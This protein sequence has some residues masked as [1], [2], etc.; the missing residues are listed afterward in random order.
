MRDGEV[1]HI[2]AEDIEK[3]VAAT[4][5]Q[6]GLRV[7]DYSNSGPFYMEPDHPAVQLMCDIYNEVMGE[8]E[9]PFVLSGGTYARHMDNTVS[10]GCEMPHEN[11]PSWVGGCHMT[12][13]GLSIDTLLQA[14]EIYIETLVR[15]QNVD[16]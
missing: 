6:W 9:K 11:M 3:R 12:N 16:F 2:T 7:A 5:Q 14:F 15:L 4:A 8:N 10:F 1:K 13:E